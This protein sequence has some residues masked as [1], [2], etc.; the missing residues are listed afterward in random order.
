MPHSTWIP[1]VGNVVLQDL[2]LALEFIEVAEHAVHKVPTHFFRMLH[3]E[4]R[5]ELGH[6]NLRVGS[7]PHIEL[8]A[9]HVG[10]AVDPVHRRNRYAS[11]ALRLLIPVA[12]ELQINSLWITCDPENI[13]SR[14]TCERAGAEFVEIV[15]VPVNCVIRQSGHSRKCRYRLTIQAT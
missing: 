10:Y 1:Q 4:S 11:R 7:G 3:T 2:E 14:R 6:I 13:G 9:G 12:R 15:D 5:E 8:Y